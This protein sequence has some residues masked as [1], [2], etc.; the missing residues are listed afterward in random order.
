MNVS[1]DVSLRRSASSMAVCPVLSVQPTRALVDEKFQIV[2]RNLH[3]K[4][5]VTVHSLH[6]SED[7]DYWEAFGHY[8]SDENGT[9][10]GNQR[11]GSYFESI[12]LQATDHF[13]LEGVELQQKY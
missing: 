4:Q 8:I 12:A 2:V 10:T 6:H 5:E 13:R 7:K 9:V 3:P 1:A 11:W